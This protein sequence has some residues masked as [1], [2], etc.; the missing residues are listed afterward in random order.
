MTKAINSIAL[1]LPFM[2]MALIAAHMAGA[3]GAGF[4]IFH[5]AACIHAAFAVGILGN[6]ARRIVCGEG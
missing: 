1:A 2:G 4:G 5:I 3:S 6:G